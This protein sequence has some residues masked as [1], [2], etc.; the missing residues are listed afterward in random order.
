M[1]KLSITGIVSLV[2]VILYAVILTA[3]EI[4]VVYFH[5]NFVEQF[6]LDRRGNGISEADLIYHAM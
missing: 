5:H 1:A 2:S 4:L 6:K 3:L